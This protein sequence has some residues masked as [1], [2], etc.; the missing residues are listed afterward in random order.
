MTSLELPR[1]AGAGAP[2]LRLRGSIKIHCPSTVCVRDDVD[3]AT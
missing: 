3:V 2:T 1:P